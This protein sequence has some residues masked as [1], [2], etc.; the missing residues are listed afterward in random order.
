MER[1]GQDCWLWIRLPESVN[2][3]TVV[4]REAWGKWQPLS[5]SVPPLVFS[6]ISRRG[7][8][9]GACKPQRSTIV[10]GAP[11]G[12]IQ[13]KPPPISD[14]EVQVGPEAKTIWRANT[15][16]QYQ[17]RCIRKWIQFKELPPSVSLKEHP[18][19]ILRSD[20][21]FQKIVLYVYKWTYNLGFMKI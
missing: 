17:I 14:K 18:H 6:H 21:Q 11:A 2:V 8:A 10:Q 7:G 20:F 1:K 15:K 4:S 16:F 3:S 5:S 12:E 19:Q 9:R 13:E